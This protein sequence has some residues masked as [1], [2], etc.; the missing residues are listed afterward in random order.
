MASRL[1][2]SRWAE[3][4]SAWL[5]RA[6]W[7]GARM[8]DS[9]EYQAIAA[10]RE[11]LPKLVALDDV[12][13]ALSAKDALRYLQRLANDHVFQ[14]ET[15]AVPIQVLGVLEASGLEFDYLWLTGMH[16][17]NWPQAPRPNPFL[18]VRLQR[19]AGVPHATAERELAFSEAALARLSASA[20]DVVISYPLQQDDRDLLPSAL[21]LA[22]PEA[23]VATVAGTGID[24]V[25]AVIQRQRAREEVEDGTAPALAPGTRVQGGASLF[26]YQASCPFR[27]F[28]ETRLHAR[29]MDEVQTGLDAAARGTLVHTALEQFWNGVHSHT[30]L[31]GLDDQALGVAIAAAAEY[32]LAEAA[33]QWPEILTP[34]FV[35]LERQRLER[36]LAEWLALEKHRAPFEVR[37]LEQ[38]EFITVGDIVVRTVID[39]IDTLADGSVLVIDYKTGR[40]SAGDWM[41][42]RPR[43]PQ[44]PLYGIHAGTR[45]GGLAFARVRPGEAAFVGITIDGVLPGVKPFDDDKKLTQQFGSW[46]ALQAYWRKLME[47]LARAYRDGDARVDPRKYPDACEYCSLTPLCRIHERHARVGRVDLEEEH[48]HD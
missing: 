18:P 38:E 44:L 22:L 12:S 45:L 39:R 13:A 9:S 40:V 1:S 48:H 15:P 36:V 37:Q 46:S 5:L 21:I 10:F 17:A 16:D 42:P 19:S 28:A 23:D 20:G 35:A 41:E 33:R 2:P 7:P 31:C 30:A 4:F 29:A 26:K 14:P 34:G 32:A 47:G 25:A 8:P 3:H 27:A 24:T 6:G 43:E 11:L